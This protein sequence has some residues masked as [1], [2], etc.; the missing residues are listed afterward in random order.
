MVLTV[1]FPSGS[2]FDQP[3]PKADVV[4]MGH[5]LHDWDLEV[6]RMLLRKA[7]DAVPE[8]G[9]F[10]VYETVIDANVRR[11]FLAL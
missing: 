6:T 3:L 5:I 10:V 2:F 4:L 7:Y 11:T 1:K 8:G 9:A